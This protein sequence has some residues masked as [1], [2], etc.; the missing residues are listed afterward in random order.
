MADPAARSEDGFLLVEA[1]VALAIVALVGGMVFET[2]WQSARTR[3]TVQHRREAVLLANSV[4][5]AATIDGV[6]MPIAAQ[7]R[8]GSL[9]WHV[10]RESFAQDDDRSGQPLQQVSVTITD[11]ADGRQLARLDGLKAA[12]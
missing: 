9:D 8:D 3:L 10:T 1:M 5:A 6:D 2:V 4:L 11:A 12:P 7:G